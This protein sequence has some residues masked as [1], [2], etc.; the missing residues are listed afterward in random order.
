MSERH[1]APQETE[2]ASA[3]AFVRVWRDRAAVLEAERLRDLRALSERD[4]ARLFAE[5]SQ[6]H[7]TFPLRPGSGMVEQ[8]R[9]LAGLRRAS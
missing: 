9:V 3:R 6:G 2:L 8:Q 5:L 1:S 4:A 7:A